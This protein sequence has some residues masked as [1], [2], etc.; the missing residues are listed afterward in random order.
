MYR[1]PANTPNGRPHT[2]CGPRGPNFAATWV[3]ATQEDGRAMPE[4]A[5]VGRDGHASPLDL[6]PG[7]GAP[8]LPDALAHLGDGLGRDGFAETGEAPR[9]VDRHPA[10]ERG[11]AVA[12]ELL[13]LALAAQTDVL[14][15][16][17]LEGR[18]QVVDL[19]QTD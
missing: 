14:V 11:G 6:V 17:E 13:R 19:G 2:R 7:G 9:R 12:Q 8:E 18:R 1:Q 5:L 16:V 15:P 4:Q 3:S 10:P